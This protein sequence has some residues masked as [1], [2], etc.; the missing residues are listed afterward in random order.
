MNFLLGSNSTLEAYQR[1][2][3]RLRVHRTTFTGYE[4]HA[5]NAHAS[6]P[7]FFQINLFFYQAI[8]RAA[9]RSLALQTSSL[10][11]RLPMG[12]TG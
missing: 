3:Q 2:C 1:F 8:M 4:F 9:L 5:S 12:L 10:S 11:L 7:L 6:V